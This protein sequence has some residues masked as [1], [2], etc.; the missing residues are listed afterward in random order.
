M[1][2]Q[3]KLACYRIAIKKVK[4]RG[5]PLTKDR[6]WDQYVNIALYSGIRDLLSKHRIE[7]YL[8]YLR[9]EGECEL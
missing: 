3:D 7:P 6:I 8:D 5:Y 4:E 1:L 9:Q 2:D